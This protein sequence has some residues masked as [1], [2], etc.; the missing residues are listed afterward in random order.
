MCL[1][2]IGNSMGSHTGSNVTTHTP[3]LVILQCLYAFVTSAEDVKKHS[4]LN[5]INIEQIYFIAVIY[6]AW[7]SIF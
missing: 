4:H 5:L 3:S 7:L 6:M 1:K 2:I